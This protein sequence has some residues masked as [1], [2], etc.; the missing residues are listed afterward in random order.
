MPDRALLNETNR[1]WQALRARLGETEPRSGSGAGGPRF[2]VSPTALYAQMEEV[3]LAWREL[4]D[5]RLERLEGRF[6]NGAWTLKDLLGHLASWAAEFRREVETVAAGGAFDY[7]IPFALSVLGPNEWNAR[8]VE[9]QRPRSL[10]AI[11]SAFEAETRRLQDL[12]LAMPREVLYGPTDFPLAP[13]GDPRIPFR[14]NVAQIV[15]G[16]CE[17]DNHHLGQIRRWLERVESER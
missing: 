16:K 7:A 2:P 3:L 1:E 11:R 12:V 6:V 8:A 15:F 10:R 14:G 5:D 17:H 13:T 4:G 9:D